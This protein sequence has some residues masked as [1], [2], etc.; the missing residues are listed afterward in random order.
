MN[1]PSVIRGW[2]AF[3][4]PSRTL[5]APPLDNMETTIAPTPQNDVNDDQAPAT[6]APQNSIDDMETTTAPQTQEEK[7]Q[8]RFRDPTTLG[9][10]VL[11]DLAERYSTKSMVDQFNQ[12]AGKNIITGPNLNSRLNNALVRKAKDEGT[13]KDEVRAALT[14][15]RKA[16][17]IRST[18]RKPW[19]QNP[20]DQRTGARPTSYVRGSGGLSGAV[21]GEIQARRASRNGYRDGR[22]S[23][24]FHRG[25]WREMEWVRNSV[26]MALVSFPFAVR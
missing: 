9:G 10:Y 26:P 11:L 23:R 2:T 24:S 18:R 7:E 3:G 16:Q 22:L 19:S 14:E 20:S 8:A 21:A 1:T 13:T 17:G 12:A 25:K 6:T 15:R 5:P 4:D